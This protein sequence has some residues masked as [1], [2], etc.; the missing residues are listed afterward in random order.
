VQ[1]FGKRDIGLSHLIA[2]QRTPWEPLL[3]GSLRDR[4]LESAAAIAADLISS[5]PSRIGMAKSFPHSMA[6]GDAGIALFLHYWERAASGP[7]LR[8][9]MD[10][11]LERAVVGVAQSRMMCGLFRGF[12]GISWVIQHVRRQRGA[13]PEGDAWEEIDA[14]IESWVE[15]E[16]VPAE[17]MEGLGGILLYVS[18]HGVREST[19]RIFDRIVLRLVH[20]ARTKGAGRAWPVADSIQKDFEWHLTLPSRERF[21][22]SEEWLKQGMAGYYKLGP[23][24]GCL[25]TAAA[26]ASAVD[27]GFESPDAKALVARV[28][29]FVL[30]QE[31]PPGAPSTF[32]NVPGTIMPKWSGGWCDG[33]AGIAAQLLHIAGV[34]G[35]DDLR[36]QALRIARLESQRRVHDVEEPNRHNYVLCHGSSGRAHIFNRLYQT[37]RESQFAEAAVYWFAEA[38]SVR[39]PGQGTGGFLVDE[40]RKDAALLDVSGFLMGAAGLGLALTA[41]SY[42]ME[43]EWDRVL[44]LSGRTDV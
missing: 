1:Y 14:A 38:L 6:Y 4:A 20:L 33:D 13:E 41:G 44:G 18:E 36:L 22:L 40:K 34:L 42:S 16:S 32:P 24:H 21:Q 37:T 3:Q 10:V 26:L 2:G 25:G 12:S 7:D 8:S 9:G 31:L 27:A 30:A 43:S 23:A 15:R 39:K 19:R 5:D 28:A 11:Y 29:E 17:L 35:R